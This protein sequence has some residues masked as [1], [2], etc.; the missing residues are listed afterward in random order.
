M[1]CLRRTWVSALTRQRLPSGWSKSCCSHSAPSAKNCSNRS[2]TSSSLCDGNWPGLNA[3]NLPAEG[4]FPVCGPA[5]MTSGGGIHEPGDVLR[6]PLLH[7]DDRLDW[8][9]WL[10]A[11][12][13]SS[14]GL[15]RLNDPDCFSHR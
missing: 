4:L 2:R 1:P 15:E 8:S 7:L 9:R 14:E 6:F 11:A 12:G 10:E 3:V 13:V 5:I